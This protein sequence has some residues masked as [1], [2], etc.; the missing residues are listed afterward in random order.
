[1]H[2]IDDTTM[3]ELNKR[4]Y[5]LKQEISDLEEYNIDLGKENRELEEENIK[6]K[7]LIIPWVKAATCPE[8]DG[9]GICQGYTGHGDHEIWQCQW[10]DVRDHLLGKL[11]DK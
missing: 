9:S 4:I 10:C 6:L 3:W 11:N 5:D 7:D 8:C 2:G 1:M